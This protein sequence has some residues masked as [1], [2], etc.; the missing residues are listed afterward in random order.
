MERQLPPKSTQRQT[1]RRHLLLGKMKRALSPV[2]RSLMGSLCFELRKSLPY[3][4]DIFLLSAFLRGTSNDE[5]AAACQALIEDFSR[6]TGMKLIART[7]ATAGDGGAMSHADRLKLR[8]SLPKFQKALPPPIAEGPP[9]H[10]EIEIYAMRRGVIS[11]HLPE[12]SE[13]D[14]A[15]LELVYLTF[16]GYWQD[17]LVQVAPPTT[18]RHRK[19][20]SPG[21]GQGDGKR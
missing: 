8:F 20:S 9:I 7:V 16:Q 18:A 5:H 10:L 3:A 4:S 2:A 19:P 12:I 21:L 1:N 17:H 15:A 11:A 13:L 6:K 14:L